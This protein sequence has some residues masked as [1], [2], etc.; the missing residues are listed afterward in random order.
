[1]KIHTEKLFNNLTK[2]YDFQ[3][4]LSIKKINQESCIVDR[5]SCIIFPETQSIIELFEIYGTGP[6]C[7][8]GSRVIG[9][10]MGSLYDSW[11]SNNLT[12]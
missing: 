12:N 1:M 11:N 9:F 6:Y 4:A 8:C 3:L 10:Y 7:I 5:N 2:V